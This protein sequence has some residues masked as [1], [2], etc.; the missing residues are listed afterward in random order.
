MISVKN[1]FL[2]FTDLAFSRSFLR[3]GQFTAK[4][5]RDALYHEP[6]YNSVNALNKTIG[7]YRNTNYTM[8][9][10]MAENHGRQL[11]YS[12]MFD[13]SNIV[14]F[15]KTDIT[16]KNRV[17]LHS[18]LIHPDYRG[19]KLEN[20]ISYN[21]LFLS[22]VCESVRLRSHSIIELK[23]HED[24]VKAYNGYRHHN[25]YTTSKQDKRYMMEKQLY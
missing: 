11:Q 7:T 2:F 21:E 17:Y 10:F 4:E 6:F 9:D 3:F 15:C 25:F 23:V 19:C 14:G 13:T 24:N 8:D 1:I 20:R 18:Y 22:C 5:V 16:Q 12:M